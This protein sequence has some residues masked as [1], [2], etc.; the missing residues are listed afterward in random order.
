MGRGKGEPAD[1]KPDRIVGGFGYRIQKRDILCPDRFDVV[2]ETGEE[3]REQGEKK[4]EGEK[5]IGAD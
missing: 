1:Q 3:E 5:K 2:K 4:R